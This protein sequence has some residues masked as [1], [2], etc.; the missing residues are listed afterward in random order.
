MNAFFELID[1][2]NAA[3]ESERGAI[4]RRIRATY[5]RPKAVLALDMSGFSVSVRR[6]GILS[7]LARIRRMQSLTAPLVPEFEGELVKFEADNLLAVFDDARRAVA[8][9]VAMNRA[10]LERELEFA[11]GIDYGAVL[12]IPGHDCFGDAV[13]VAHKLGEDAAGPGEILVSDAVRG[14]LGTP[15]PYGLKELNLSLS[16]LQ[17]TAYQVLMRTPG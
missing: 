6:S 16:G 2:L 9:A 10:V 3:P 14:Q 15:P 12:Y 1:E 7:C 17:F 11:T 5:E 4:E 8:A 13:N